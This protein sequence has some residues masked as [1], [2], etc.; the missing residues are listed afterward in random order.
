MIQSR[1]IIP[2]KPQAL[3]AEGKGGNAFVL[4]ALADDADAA[5]A[6]TAVEGVALCS[7]SPYVH[8]PPYSTNMPCTGSGIHTEAID[9]LH[10]NDALHINNQACFDGV[11]NGLK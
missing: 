11:F 6:C 10:E 9:M 1:F 8:E 3:E 2:L 4:D 7:P 5:A